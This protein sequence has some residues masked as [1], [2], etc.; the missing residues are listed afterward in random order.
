MKLLYETVL[1]R[2]V[3]THLFYE[4]MVAVKV[5]RNVF[6]EGNTECVAVWVLGAKLLLTSLSSKM[7]NMNKCKTELSEKGKAFQYHHT[8]LNVISKFS[9][10]KVTIF[11]FQFRCVFI[12]ES[13]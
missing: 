1:T 3:E 6:T 7:L 4:I 13:K 12:A 5:M 9:T 11:F 8:I 10:L 2:F